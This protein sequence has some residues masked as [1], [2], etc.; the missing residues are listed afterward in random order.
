MDDLHQRGS[1]DKTI[2]QPTYIQRKKSI[3]LKEKHYR[4]FITDI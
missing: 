1:F 2:L 3:N 4:L